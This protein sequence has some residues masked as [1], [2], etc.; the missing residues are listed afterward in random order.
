MIINMNE[1]NKMLQE[2]KKWF[3]QTAVIGSGNHVLD[4]PTQAM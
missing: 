4:N 3:R 1:P 2:K